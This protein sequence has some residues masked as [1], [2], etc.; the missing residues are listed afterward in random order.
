MTDFQICHIN[1]QITTKWYIADAGRRSHRNFVTTVEVTGWRVMHT[2]ISL[3]AECI[4]PCA[5]GAMP[6]PELEAA[7]LRGLVRDYPNRGNQ[8]EAALREALRLGWGCR[9]QL[10]ELQPGARR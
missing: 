6:S 10:S 3:L 2:A 8:L 4:G 1:R 5:S 7:A 9:H